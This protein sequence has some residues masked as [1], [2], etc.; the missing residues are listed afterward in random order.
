MRGIRQ[1]LPSAS[2]TTTSLPS[3]TDSSPSPPASNW[4]SI[5]PFF[6]SLSEMPFV[7]P[8]GGCETYAVGGGAIIL[9]LFGGAAPTAATAAALAVAATGVVAL[10][11]VSEGVSSD[12]VCGADITDCRSDCELAEFMVLDRVRLSSEACAGDPAPGARSLLVAAWRSALIF[13]R[14]SLFSSPGQSAGTFISHLL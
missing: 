5:L 10:G 2:K 1:H 3:A 7:P 14:S 9:F 4:Y 8:P 12:G 13:F 6:S 11:G